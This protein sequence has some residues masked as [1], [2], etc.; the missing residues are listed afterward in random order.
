[1][2]QPKITDIRLIRLDYNNSIGYWNLIRVDSSEGVW[3]LGEAYWGPGLHDVINEFLKPELVGKNPMDI[4]YICTYLR[5][6]LAGIHT[7]NGLIMAAI[8]G[9][10]IALW[11]LAGKLS[12]LPVYRL[13]GGTFRD[14][15]RL[16][17]TGTPDGADDPAVCRDYAAQIKDEPIIQAG[18]IHLPQGPGLGI[19]LNPDVVIPLLKAGDVYWG[20]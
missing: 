18:H 20:D 1:M 12:D 11:D 2:T 8:S 19:E 9:I 13:L 6:R 5:E 7:A 10:E 3:G 4:D 15:V 14:R 17:R 16:Y